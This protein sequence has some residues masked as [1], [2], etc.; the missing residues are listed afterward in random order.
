M[1]WHPACA[2]GCTR[3][4]GSSPQVAPARSVTVSCTDWR[5]PPTTPQASA[6]MLNV[7]QLRKHFL[8]LA[9]A[10]AVIHRV[11]V[12]HGALGVTKLGGERPDGRNNPRNTSDT[13]RH[14][15]GACHAATAHG[16]SQLEPRSQRHERGRIGEIREGGGTGETRAW[17][18]CVWFGRTAWLML[19]VSAGWR[20]VVFSL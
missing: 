12:F 5:Q 2:R 1:E 17:C 10:G 18:A 7:L 19:H 3:P 13:P 15:G 20:I 11:V 8:E 9:S 6:H 4:W 14:H 16:R